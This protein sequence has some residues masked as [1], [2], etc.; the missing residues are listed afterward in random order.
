MS[1]RKG[2]L[3]PC[4]SQ[5]PSGDTPGRSTGPSEP[6]PLASSADTQPSPSTG[7]PR[8]YIGDEVSK[9]RGPLSFVEKKL[10]AAAS[11]SFMTCWA[12]RPTVSRSLNSVVATQPSA[13]AEAGR[14]TV[15]SGSASEQYRTLLR[16]KGVSSVTH[17]N[18]PSTVASA[19]LLQSGSQHEP[20]S[21]APAVASLGQL[22]GWLPETGSPTSCAPQ[23]LAGSPATAS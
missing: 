7:S 17:S 13:R 1:C 18:T 8:W 20:A 21:H 23:Q 16:E 5:E 12:V 15:E 22:Y 14:L 4:V 2:R 9:L 11:I 10:K 19:P 3:R 6:H